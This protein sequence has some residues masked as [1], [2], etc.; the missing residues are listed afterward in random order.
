MAERFLTEPEPDRGK[1]VQVA[2]DVLRLTAN[3]PSIM[4]YHGT[5][6]YVIEM[7]GK[8]YVLDPGPAND[9]RH[10]QAIVECV[11]NRCKG[12]IISHHHSD[13]L[14]LTPQLRDKLHSPVYASAL[15]AD[16]AF[17]PDV[18]LSDG[19]QVA[20]LEVLHTPG[21]ASDHLCFAR[22]DGILFSGDHVMSWN[23][24]IVSTPDGNMADYCNQ[25][26]RLA[27]RT[28]TLYLPGHGPP[29]ADPIPYTRQLLE[30]RLQREKAII[31]ALSAGPQSAHDLATS[32]YRKTDRRLAQAA[33][34]NVEAHLEKLKSEGVVE[35]PDGGDWRLIGKPR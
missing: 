30:H 3:N 22:G 21:H 19:D 12:I 4:T 23:S 13:H 7:A 25:L 34:R 5:N 17:Y 33:R 20:D 8:C 24:S 32:L 14:G 11:G 26:R 31:V 35:P 18:A 28:D 1:P 9:Q 27:G 6:T 10:L 29:L 15:L 16:D 2:E